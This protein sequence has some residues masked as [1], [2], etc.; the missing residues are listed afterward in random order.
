MG[1]HERWIVTLWSIFYFSLIATF[2]LGIAAGLTP[3]VD[4]TDAFSV[5]HDV[6]M[7]DLVCETNSAH[8]DDFYLI[9]KVGAWGSFLIMLTMLA[10]YVFWKVKPDY[11][12]NTTTTFMYAAAFF[13]ALGLIGAAGLNGDTFAYTNSNDKSTPLVHTSTM[14]GHPGALLFAVYEAVIVLALFTF[15]YA[16]RSQDPASEGSIVKPGDGIVKNG[17]RVVNAAV[18]NG[19]LPL[20]FNKPYSF[21][22]GKSVDNT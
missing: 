20:K 13:G 17:L 18:F 14:W 12:H 15:N 16:S 9:L 6:K 1:N 21:D 7:W 5:N 8:C 19:A 10:T 11:T 22:S 3:W 2:A 4:F